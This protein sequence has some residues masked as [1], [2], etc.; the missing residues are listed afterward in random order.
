[1]L[2]TSSDSEMSYDSEDSEIYSTAG[3]NMEI[4]TEESVHELCTCRSSPTASDEDV[5]PHA[6]NQGSSLS[7]YGDIQPSSKVFEMLQ[8]NH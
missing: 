5:A 3:Y 1:M 4:E 6:D 7:F 8:A 2:T